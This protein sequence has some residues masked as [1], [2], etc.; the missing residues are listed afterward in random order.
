MFKIKDN[1]A[2]TSLE[3]P[4]PWGEDEYNPLPFPERVV[5][6]KAPP[7]LTG[8][9]LV[10]IIVSI[11]VLVLISGAVYSTFI[12]HQR[13]YQLGQER[14]E[15][16]QNGRVILERLSRELRQAK[17]IITSLPDESDVPGSS[18]PSEVVFQDGHLPVITEEENPQSA[19]LNTI[20]L[21]NGA[22]LI[23]DYYKGSFIKIISGNGTGEIR[24]II[25]YNGVTKLATIKETWQTIPNTSS[26]YKID[27][28]YYYIRY[29][30]E[31][32]N[33]KRQ[34]I[35]YY[36]SED[37]NHFVAWNAIPPQGQTLEHL[38]LEDDII[39]EYVDSLKFWGKP[40]I[41]I[42]LKLK[43]GESEVNL[44]TKILGR[45]L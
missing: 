35:V 43:K 27:T 29:Y 18:P 19:T 13:A 3:S 26:V 28:S 37:P 38:I 5:G 12:L 23:D 9:T 10:E 11:T 24:K 34:V 4:V 2:F 1:N 25:E 39:G 41:N 44:Q 15:I 45:N 20:T 42:F 16:N 33:L 7:F 21:Y 30:L 32:K 17:E 31:N 8:F 6:F 22:S 40:L 14:E 36:F